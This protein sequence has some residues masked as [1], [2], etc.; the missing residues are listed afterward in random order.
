MRPPFRVV[1]GIRA[2]EIIATGRGIRELRRLRK[3][4]GGQRWR[5][6]KGVATVELA[7]GRHVEAELH[8]YEAHGVG[9]RE[10]KLKQILHTP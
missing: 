4:Y 9:R 6:M 10:M 7:G 3:S 1:G 2:I 8:W 5:K